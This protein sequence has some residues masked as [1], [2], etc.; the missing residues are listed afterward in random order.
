M[1]LHIFRSEWESAD[2][3]YDA[4][5]FGAHVW[6]ATAGAPFA[7]LMDNLGWLLALIHDSYQQAPTLVLVLSALL[8]LPV[9]AMVSFLVQAQAR[10]R[11]RQAAARAAQRRAQSSQWSRDPDSGKNIPAWPS[12]AWL[13]ISGGH[14]DTVPLEGQMIR[15][16]RHEDNDIRL[17]DSSVHRYHA[18]IERTPQEDFVIIDLSG[19]DGNGV[20]VNGEQTARTRLADGDVIELGRAKLKFENAPL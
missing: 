2:V 7:S 12:Q 15:I 4:L 9:V 8:V 3:P 1:L 10:R 19:K 6:A 11:K 20:R 18:I 16:G 17:A 13:T 5:P 14:R